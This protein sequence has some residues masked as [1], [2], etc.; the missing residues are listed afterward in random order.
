MIFSFSGASE[1][2][3]YPVFRLTH[4]TGTLTSINVNGNVTVEGIATNHQRI[5]VLE[6]ACKFIGEVS[7]GNSLNKY[8]VERVRING[9]KIKTL[10]FQDAKNL[11]KINA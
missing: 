2:V 7:I 6:I 10:N 3:D 1:W 5:K 9:G 8:S 11:R 4:E